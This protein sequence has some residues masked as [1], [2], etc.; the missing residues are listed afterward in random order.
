M[1]DSTKPINKTNNLNFLCRIGIY[2]GGLIIQSKAMRDTKQ[3][4]EKLYLVY[5]DF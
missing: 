2:F 3:S 4:Q 5:L 1:F